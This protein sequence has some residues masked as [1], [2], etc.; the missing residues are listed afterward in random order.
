MG[1]CLDGCFASENM[2]W[3][4]PSHHKAVAA[5]THGESQTL[6]I[7]VVTPHGDLIATNG[8]IRWGYNGVP[9]EYPGMDWAGPFRNMVPKEGYKDTWTVKIR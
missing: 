1:S 4:D 9:G 2:I 3:V 8:W 6:T 7:E 5:W